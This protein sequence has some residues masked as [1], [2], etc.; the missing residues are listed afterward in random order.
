V[1]DARAADSRAFEVARAVRRVVL[2]IL[3]LN[4]MVAGAKG[5]YGW[6]SG[7]LAVASDALHS[8]LDAAG[9][10]IGA[11][12]L[13]AAASPPDEGHPYGHQKIEIVAA[14]LI[15]VLI[16]GGSLRFGWSAVEA[17]LS[18]RA[19]PPVT[20]VGFAVVGGTLVVNLFVASWEA[21]KGRELGSAFLIADAAH[22]ASDVVVTIGVILSLIASR[23]GVRWADSAA[24]LGV[25]AV[26]VVV[27]YRILSSNLN[28]LLDRAALD[29][30]RIRAE[31]LAVPGVLSCH[32]IRSRGLEGAVLVDL[33]LQVDGSMP[34]RAAHAISHEVEDRLKQKFPGVADVT[35][36]VEPE[37]EPEEG[38]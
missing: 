6:W 16:A 28:I 1:R 35:I 36:H 25:L 11:L 21:K 38:L 7:S 14:A 18:G 5:A 23:I 3:A 33:H 32:R 9:N 34:L 30:D 22:T 29:A 19:A 2:I 27:A 12:V 26:V 24:A 15:G 37:E 10:V 17:L 8:L 20:G 13:R 4:A 31:V